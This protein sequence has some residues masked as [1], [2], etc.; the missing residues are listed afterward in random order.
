MNESSEK[1]IQQLTSHSLMLGRIAGEVSEFCTDPNCTTLS[2][3][4]LMKA[5][6]LQLQAEELERLAYDQINNSYI[7]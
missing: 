6:L 1:E 7:P 2:A 4:R 5:S 3:V